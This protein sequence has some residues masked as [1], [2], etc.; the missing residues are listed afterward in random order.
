MIFDTSPVHFACHA[1]PVALNYRSWVSGPNTFTPSSTT[2]S[3]QLVRVFMGA[4]DHH[5]YLSIP[6]AY[7][8][9]YSCRRFFTFQLYTVF[10][11]F[12][13]AW[14]YPMIIFS[15]LTY[16]WTKDVMLAHPCDSESFL[17]LK[18]CCI[19]RFLVPIVGVSVSAKPSSSYISRRNETCRNPDPTGASWLNTILT[20]VSYCI[21][22]V[23]RF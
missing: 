11:L 12:G 5:L 17:Y 13:L 15:G 16:A 14:A 9:P 1:S 8:L 4:Q 7:D 23:S 21:A 10:P 18:H 3:R 20:V 19:S 22:H 6:G 2:Y